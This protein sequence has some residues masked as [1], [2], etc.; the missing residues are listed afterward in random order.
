MRVTLRTFSRSPRLRMTCSLA[1]ALG[2][3]LL[4]RPGAAIADDAAA[5][6]SATKVASVQSIDRQA[7]DLGRIA[8]E[9]WGFAETALREHRS[10]AVLAD[11]AEKKGFK[12]ERNVDGM[13]TAFIA[14]YGSGRPII[15]IIGEFDALPGLSQKAEP[16]QSPLVQGA[17]GH[18]C[19]HNL[20]GAASLGA[21]V[22]VKEQI[23]AGKLSGTLR[24]YGTPA[25]ENIGG[26][27]YMARDGLFNDLDVLLAWH[28]D[29]NTKAD[30]ASTSAMVDLAIEFH[31]RAAQAARDP[32]DG[33]SA[34]DA[35]E[36][37]TH[38]I[39][40]M[41]EHVHP[42]S[43][44]HYTIAA[45]GDVPN[46][47]PEYG[48]VWLWLRDPQRA[49]VESLLARVRKLAEGAATMTETSSTVTV[50]GGSWELLNNTAGAQLI[51]ANLRW[52]WPITYTEQEQSFARA[53]QQ[54][55][56]IPQV[57]MD[58]EVRSL[59]GQETLS[60]STDIGDV[61]WIVPVLHFTVATAPKGTPW[62]S[63][64]VVAASGTSI[65]HKGLVLAAKTLAATTVD[66]YEQPAALT[67]VRDEFETRRGEVVFRAYVPDGPP[68]VPTN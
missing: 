57:G 14:S 56:G 36:L 58:T 30:T 42:S 60:S 23:A 41:R 35:L 12:V 46:V 1:V 24:Y 26:K 43:R 17:P 55:T 53:L 62:H 48:K 32:W 50:Q 39:N 68:P 33:R 40:L 21:A 8:D 19:G 52:L 9:I 20:F 22:A 54:A 61:S 38:G 64:P 10:A 51:D 13:P 4:V 44:M 45:G 28:P 11:Y 7:A 16:E 47:V 65:G 5:S 25:E 2:C 63:W 37:F 27:A 15:G 6:P 66:L 31:G 49:E 67:A 3:L 18:G 59:D 29:D 34:V